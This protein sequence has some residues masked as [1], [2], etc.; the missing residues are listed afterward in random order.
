MNLPVI[1]RPSP[2]KL[3]VI[4]HV[5]MP[6]QSIAEILAAIPELPPEIWVYGIVRIGEWEIPQDRWHLVRPKPNTR[7][8]VHV[9]LRPRG[10]GGGEGGSKNIFATIAAIALIVVASAVSGGAAAGAFGTTLFAAGSTSAALLAA[11][12]SIVGALA[13][14]ALA[15]SPA[16][17]EASGTKKRAQLGSA[18]IRGNVLEAFEPIPFVTGTL[19]VAPPHLIT[20]WSESVNDDQFVYAIVGLNGAHTFTDIRLNDAGIDTFDNVD[21]EVRDV[22]TDDSDIT[23]I[24]NQVSEIQIGSELSPHKVKD[25]ATDELQDIVTPANSYPVWQSGRTQASPDEVWLSFFWSSLVNQVDAGGTTPGGVAIRIRIREVGDVAWINLPEFHAQRERLEPFRG[26]IKLRWAVVDTT[27]VRPDQ[28]PSFPPW[29]F[30]FYAQNADNAEGFDTHSYFNP[31]AGK[32]AA[33]ALSDPNGTVI[34]FLDPATFPK[35]TYEIQVQRGY[36]YTASTLVASTYLLSGAIPYFFTHI[37]ASSPP[38]IRKEQAKVPTKISWQSLSG[39]WNQYP[40]Q[41]KGMSLLAV[42]AKN[43]AISSLTV[44][45]QGW[46]NSWD[47]VDWDTFEP[48]NNPADWWRY[49]ALGGQSIRTPFIASQLDDAAL[50]DW[51]D[52][53]GDGIAEPIRE[54]NA[55]FSG[56]QGL[57]DVLRTIAGC[58]HAAARI[59]DKIGVVIER[60]RKTEVPIELF[61]QRNT[62]GLSIRRAF[63]RVPDGFRVRFSDEDNDYKPTEIFVYRNPAGT[64]IEAIDYIGITSQ[65]RA[66][67]RAYLDLKQLLRRAS[68]YN[69]ETDIQN[70]YCVKGSL[71]VLAHDTISRHYDGARVVSVQTSGA[72]V[73]G[74][75]VDVPLRLSLIGMVISPDGDEVLSPS[76]DPV[77]SGDYPAGVVIQLKDGTTL[78]KQIV[79]VSDTSVVTF[80]TPFTIPAASILEAECLVVVGPFSSVEKRMLVLG[81][82][83]QNEYTAALT[84]VDEAPNVRWLWKDGAPILTSDASQLVA[85]I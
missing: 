45:A 2:F 75:T 72:N 60:D 24:T 17:Q 74:L 52:F 22:V 71:V 35:G 44:Q 47:G 25:D 36:G 13:L 4:Q 73:T 70:L 33:K 85:A 54:C 50:A 8:L 53:C 62:R 6:G 39:V 55:F 19:R 46:A 69:F 59:S 10:G 79:E 26:T 20:P 68:L 65:D 80:T 77:I 41:E 64:E 34:V 30:A 84:L 23:L 66:I 37:A 5:A 15:P 43:T 18:S 7:H 12:I 57:D 58:G 63:P 67:E 31:G 11:G 81:V 76:G 21:Y 56:R 48:T 29:K 49:L 83:P 3:E 28:N 78:T 27:L 1:V 61:S 9:G 16:V 14:S 51:H 38:S 42:R 32:L 40:L 82:Q